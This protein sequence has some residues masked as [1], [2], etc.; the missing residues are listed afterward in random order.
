M[1]VISMSDPRKINIGTAS[2]IRCDMPS[3][4]R[5]TITTSGVRVVKAR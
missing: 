5:P 2:M 4:S 3:S 1:P